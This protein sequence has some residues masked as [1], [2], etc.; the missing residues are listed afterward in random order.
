MTGFGV[1]PNLY[2]TADVMARLPA[3]KPLSE[4]SMRQIN[5]RLEENP[6]RAVGEIEE[7]A[8]HCR[9]TAGQ[10]SGIH[11]QLSPRGKVLSRRERSGAVN[12]ESTSRCGE[13][14]CP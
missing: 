10:V 6:N 3:H 4:N 5:R 11:G 13:T 1:I 7:Y 12:V 8:R 14:R 9:W 2:P